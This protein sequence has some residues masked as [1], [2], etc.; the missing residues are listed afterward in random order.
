MQ[1]LLFKNTNLFSSSIVGFIFLFTLSLNCGSNNN[2]GGNTAVDTDSDG[3]ADNLDKFPD[4]PCASVDADG[5]RIA[6]ARHDLS[7]TCTEA[8]RNI[9][10]VDKIPNNPC[11]SV[12]DD[13]DGVP[14]SKLDLSSTCTTTQRDSFTV[15]KF[16]NNPCASADA[17]G[18]GIADARH[19]LSDT[20]TEALRNMVA[21]DKF[22]NN[23]CASVDTDGDGVPDNKLDL[24]NTCTT[25]QR[26]A[27]T[28][29]KFPDNACASVDADGDDI[30]DERHDVSKT[31]TEALRNMV[32]IDELPKDPCISKNVAVTMRDLDKDGV[33]NHLDKFP[34]D[35]CASL[36]TD[37]DGRPDDLHTNIRC[38]SV[39]FTT[40]KIDD[41]PNDACAS[42]N[43]D[44]DRD[45]DT[46]HT[47]RSCSDTMASSLRQDKFPNDP[48]V[49]RDTDEDGFP[50]FISE[51]CVYSA[52][53]DPKADPRETSF[54]A[55][56]FDENPCASEDS[57]G[58]EFPDELHNTPG[59]RRS[60]ITAC[61]PQALAD[62]T[63][64]V[65][66]FPKDAC[67]SV[68]GDGDGY[69][70]RI[71]ES[72]PYS[73]TAPA[74]HP[75]PNN[76]VTSL[77][78]DVFPGDACRSRDDD[79]DGYPNEVFTTG[80]ADP[81]SIREDKFPNDP[82]ASLDNDNDGHPESLHSESDNCTAAALRDKLYE[83]IYKIGPSNSAIDLEMHYVP[84]KKTFVGLNDDTSVSIANDFLMMKEELKYGLYEKVGDWATGPSSS[85]DSATGENCYGPTISSAFGRPIDPVVR[86]NEYPLTRGSWLFSITLSNALTEYYNKT[87]A[88]GEKLIPVYRVSKANTAV[89]R[90]N[91]IGTKANPT[92]YIMPNAT[93]FRL[94]TTHEW[95][96]AARY[97]KDYNH[98]GDITDCFLR[99]T[100]TGTINTNTPHPCSRA[101]TAGFSL[102]REYTPG[103]YASG[104]TV[105]HDKQSSDN[106]VPADAITTD[107]VAVYMRRSPRCSGARK[108]RAGDFVTKEPNALVLHDM[109]GKV[110]EAI[111]K[112]VENLDLTKDIYVNGFYGGYT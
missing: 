25:T 64:K 8:L 45:P 105:A 79:G 28:V 47:S 13:S 37:D 106:D 73:A 40:L 102:V 27:F 55:D 71:K 54:I 109:S 57:D 21:V 20:C 103:K 100:S 75:K 6:D 110:E 89:L 69:P 24:S 4:N 42:V 52:N 90:T 23:P 107:D 101:V 72:C 91:K 112:I 5:D 97:I 58:D 59:A 74:E 49:S 18:D 111:L 50:D 53:P 86:K 84:A 96:L 67:A 56:A 83:K 51:T 63:L 70:E 14:D 68:D 12:D 78:V 36:D 95:E 9:V 80:C 38:K 108:L 22:P 93:G 99:N 82:C 29:D 34:R 62:N 76:A 26:D 85:C 66:A 94:A 61:T 10:V 30:A 43:T 7:D 87:N 104:A 1:K 88:A 33:A 92:F 3:I 39:S 77:L 2:A 11:A 32:I 19:D 41:F 98:D 44:R 15:D 60:G 65:D 16:L 81:S 35:P 46:L 48:C 31:C 17:D